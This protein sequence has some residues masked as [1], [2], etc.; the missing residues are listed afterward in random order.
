MAALDV[1]EHFPFDSYRDKQREVLEVAAEKLYVEDQDY[2][3]I[4]APT[5]VGKSP[6]NVA[7]GRMADSAFYLAA[8]KKLRQQLADD[9][10]LARHIR[11]LKARR[12]YQCGVTG[13]DCKSCSINRSSEQSCSNFDDCTY[14]QRKMAAKAGQIAVLTFAFL[15][16][17][18]NIPAD[19]GGFNDRELLIVDECQSLEGQAASMFAGFE[20]GPWNLPSEVYAGLLGHLDIY[21]VERHPAVYDELSD[22][23]DRCGEFVAEHDDTEDKA[24]EVEQA[25]SMIRRLRWFFKEVDDLGRPWVVDGEF[26]QYRGNNRPKITMK[27]V[28]VDRFLEHHVWDRADK[29]V[30]SSA[31]IPFRHDVDR[32]LKRIGITGE[33]TMI[34][35]DM[36][37]PAENRPVHTHTEI[38]SMS[39]GGCDAHWPAIMQKLNELSGIHWGENGLVHT[40]S[41]NR[42]ERVYDDA[43]DYPNLR[44]NVMFHTGKE[45]ADVFLRQWQDADKDIVVTPSMTEGVDL[46]GDQCRWQVL[47]KAPMPSPGDPRVAYLLDERKDWNWYNNKAATEIVQSVGRAVRSPDDHADYYVLDEKIEDL[48]SNRGVEF[49]Q[50]FTDA[51]VTEPPGPEQHDALQ[52]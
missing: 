45:P 44:G 10:V 21:D 19:R 46:A 9:D 32:W 40:A 30:L 8:Q 43:S 36:P 37:F 14:W 39:S 23:L 48:R 3:V 29:I 26:T 52:W 35:V 6:I 47:L 20:V 13:D 31:T 33:G 42:A 1:D 41:Y 15:I 12:D 49:P 51:I 38:A 7:L 27:P 17:D 2:V 18:R 34:P 50:W 24:D 11:D 5:G 25:E 16:A 28:M 22:L 4:D